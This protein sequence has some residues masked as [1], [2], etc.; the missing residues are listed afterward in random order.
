M[1]NTNTEP[2]PNNCRVSV[3]ILGDTSTQLLSAAIKEC[4]LEAGIGTDIFEAGYNQIDY[5]VFDDNSA[6]YAKPFDFILIYLSSE[7]LYDRFVDTD[8]NKRSS[9]ADDVI[10]RI[11]SLYSKIR[12]KSVGKIILYNF[13]APD[14]DI[15]GNFSLLEPLS[16]TFQIHKLNFLLNSY[17]ISKQNIFIADFN[18]LCQQA[19]YDNITDKR[20]YYAAKITVNMEYIPLMAKLPADII[21]AALG[22]IKKCIVFDLDNTVWGG[23]IGD[24][25]MDR[26]EIGELG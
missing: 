7:K 16:F 8:R 3:A 5:M 6:L 11:D 21:S 13:I 18:K 23:V 24:D 12:S 10:S 19:G 20:Y 25:G 4:C 2:A 1:K 22:K 26:I 15:F 9:F 14:N 17:T